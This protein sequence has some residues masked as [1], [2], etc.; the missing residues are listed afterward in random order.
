MGYIDDLRNKRLQEFGE[1]LSAMN[2]DEKEDILF[3]ESF[4]IVS[5]SYGVKD[6]YKM[7]RQLNDAIKKI[8]AKKLQLVAKIHELCSNFEIEI[9]K[10]KE[11]SVKDCKVLLKQIRKALLLIT[12]E[13]D[14]A[15]KR[16][17]KVKHNILL[18]IGNLFIYILSALLSFGFSALL[19]LNNIVVNAIVY[20]ISIIAILCFVAIQ[21]IYT[22]KYLQAIKAKVR[23]I[24]D[25]SIKRAFSTLLVVWWY[26]FLL[27]IVNEWNTNIVMYTFSAIFALYIIF[28]VFDTFLSLQFFDEIESSLSLIAAIII[29]L[30]YFTESIDNE[31]AKQIGSGILLS[32]CFLLHVLIVKKFILDKKPVQDI[33][34][35][36]NVILI[37]ATTIV[38]TIVAL[39]K[40]LWVIPTEGQVA[41]NTLF[42]AVIGV[43]AAILGGG[44]TLAGVA[45]TIKR[46]QEIRKEDLKNEVKPFFG[47]LNITDERVEE[48]YKHVYYFSIHGNECE[49]KLIEG[50]FVNSDKNSFILKHISIGESVYAPD[51]Q[52]LISKEEIFQI[53]IF[54]DD[55]PHDDCEIVL[56]VEDQ[57]GNKWLY[58]LAKKGTY[59]TSMKAQQGENHE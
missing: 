55:I 53:S 37:V 56:V 54:V 7:L 3:S 46:N 43:Y 13:Y 34:G 35:I 30:F 58:D 15:I 45:W 21:I 44:L 48:A 28:L 8:K 17:K 26:I 14:V 23:G 50:S 10:N 51:R 4:S 42:S 16:I 49:K 27:A 33:F 39:Y 2:D 9:K 40:L 41:D 1:Q 57:N 19:Y 38:L 32:A 22:V 31:I 18:R 24:I 36:M 20:P 11:I 5:F 12:D 6:G 47:L 25:F 52:Y 29:G 59:I